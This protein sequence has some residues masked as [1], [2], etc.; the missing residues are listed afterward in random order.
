MAVLVDDALLLRVLAGDPP[1]EL[2]GEA[3]YTTG[4]WYFRLGQALRGRTDGALSRRLGTLPAQRQAAV[5][6]LV[7]DL[8][9]GVGLLSLRILVPVIRRLDP[10]GRLNLLSGE[11]LAA[12][13]VLTATV[14][15]CDGC[16]AA[17]L[18]LRGARPPVRGRPLLRA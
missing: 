13:Y 14:L 10:R 5:M 1:A 7:D 11:A 3:V 2:N 16:P 15:V 12:A 6:R 4:L 18:R 17:A 8:P 9:H